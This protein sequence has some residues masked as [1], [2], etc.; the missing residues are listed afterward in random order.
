MN[1][2]FY[3]L[4]IILKNIHQISPRSHFVTSPKY[5]ILSDI[6]YGARWWGCITYGGYPAKYRYAVFLVY[7]P[8]STTSQLKLLRLSHPLRG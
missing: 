4:L 3:N 5:K 7:R 8:P 2:I 6:A 1:D